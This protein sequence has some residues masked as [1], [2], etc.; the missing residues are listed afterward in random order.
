MTNKFHES[1]LRQAAQELRRELLAVC[2]AA[3]FE[4]RQIQRSQG[5]H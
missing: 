5:H 1:M 3:I 4:Q 2:I